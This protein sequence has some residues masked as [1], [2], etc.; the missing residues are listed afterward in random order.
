V[1]FENLTTS[2]QLIKPEIA[3]SIL[4][5]VVVLFDLIFDKRKNM[6]PIISIIGLLITAYYVVQQFGLDTFAFETGKFGF[7]LVAVDSFAAFFKLVVLLSSI[8]IILFSI[9]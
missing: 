3:L 1:N 5:V 7:G 8:F 4:L 2:L 9:T 6:L